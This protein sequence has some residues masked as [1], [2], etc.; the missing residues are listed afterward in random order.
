MVEHPDQGVDGN[1]VLLDALA[2]LTVA[3]EKSSR[4]LQKLYEEQRA[5]EAET[6]ELVLYRERL[7]EVEVAQRRLR[8]VLCEASQTL[9]GELSD[10]ARRKLAGLNLGEK[11]EE[12]QLRAVVKELLENVV[13]PDAAR[14]LQEVIFERVGDH[15]EKY[16]ILKPLR[17]CFIYRICRHIARELGRRS[18]YHVTRSAAE[19]GRSLALSY[20]LP[21]PGTMRPIQVHLLDACARSGLD[22]RSAARAIGVSAGTFV[23]WAMGDTCPQPLYEHAIARFLREAGVDVTGPLTGRRARSGARQAVLPADELRALRKKARLT[24]EKAARLAGV[25]PDQLGRAERGISVNAAARERLAAILRTG[26][27]CC[28]EGPSES[29]PLPAPA[30][31]VAESGA[32]EPGRTE[33]QAQE[34]CPVSSPKALIE[35]RLK[36]G[37][38]PTE[39]ARLA[40]VSLYE[41]WAGERGLSVYPHVRDR[42]E[43]I[44]RGGYPVSGP[45][46]KAG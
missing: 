42:L 41:L 12:E 25:S 34:P 15:V 11:P 43:A 39:A 26:Y 17:K 20:P 24:I 40:G 32:H 46:R 1:L 28:G 29:G 9:Y 3:A 45:E 21:E 35:Q 6:R 4:A 30:A 38:S 2:S 10:R 13:D 14:G 23:R 5:R 31:E 22:F 37:L 18:A 7:G 19:R 8:A 33:A 16:P 27:P 44:I 36:A